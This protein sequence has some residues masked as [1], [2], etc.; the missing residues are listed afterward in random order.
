MSG[1]TAV[2]HAIEGHIT[3]GIEPV[4]WMAPEIFN[5]RVAST[6]SDV[7]SFGMVMY[8]VLAGND[9]YYEFA[10]FTVIAKVVEGVTPS[11]PEM[12]DNDKIWDLM[13]D[14]WILKPT[15]RPPIQ[16]VIRR[17]DNL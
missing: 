5:P 13:K 4:R 1:P 11:R 7:W 10:M 3:G 6:S 17:L 9:P 14:C 8:E 15:E 16:E 12:I 2:T